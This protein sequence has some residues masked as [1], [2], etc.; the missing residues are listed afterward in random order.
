MEK[1]PAVDVVADD[2]AT[3]ALDVLVGEAGYRRFGHNP[4]ILGESE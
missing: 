3:L 1:D 4:F 2:L